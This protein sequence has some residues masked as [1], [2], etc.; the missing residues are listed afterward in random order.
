[1]IGA[2]LAQ[3]L[4]IER[5]TQV[6]PWGR[7]SFEESLNQQHHC[8]VIECKNRVLAY[9]IA[10]PV[11]QELHVLNLAVARQYQS[12]GLGHVL[13]QDIVDLATSLKLERILLEVRIGNTAARSLYQKWQFKQIALRKAYYRT[14]DGPREDALVM[15]K[16]VID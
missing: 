5:S 11:L 10:C 1:M 6:M 2:D 9:H 4:A 14:R 7:L 8:R 13:L 3:V 15:L 16:K 12:L